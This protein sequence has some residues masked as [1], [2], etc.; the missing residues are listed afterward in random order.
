[1][2]SRAERSGV[3]GTGISCPPRRREPRRSSL[4]L[5]VRRS[6]T[7][8]PLSPRRSHLAAAAAS[9]PQC[10]FLHPGAGTDARG[11]ERVRAPAPMRVR[12][13]VHMVARAW[14]QLVAGAAATTRACRCSLRHN[15]QARPW[16]S[17]SSR[18]PPRACSSVAVSSTGACSVASRFTRY[19]RCT[20][21]DHRAHCNSQNL[22]TTTT[23][24]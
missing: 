6:P 21:H 18:S 11:G 13:R 10:A 22:L 1:M 20:R 4:L 5:L 8:P 19:A 23:L 7:A 17:R 12:A 2:V 9:L 24:H 16:T 14:V 15:L 3:A